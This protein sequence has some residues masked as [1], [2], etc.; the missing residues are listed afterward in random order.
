[1]K[2]KL[3]DASAA[4]EAE[5]AP[6]SRRRRKRG[7]RPFWALGTCRRATLIP[8]A[9]VASSTPGSATS[10]ATHGETIPPRVRG[11]A[12]SLRAT[13]GHPAK[14]EAVRGPDCGLVRPRG[15][16][17]SCSFFVAS[18]LSVFLVFSRRASRSEALSLRA[19]TGA[20]GT[21][22]WLSP[23]SLPS[24]FLSAFSWAPSALPALPLSANA[25][26]GGGTS[27]RVVASIPPSQRLRDG[28][29]R[30]ESREPCPAFSRACGGLS[31]AGVSSLPQGSSAS[32]RGAHHQSA[33]FTP[34][35]PLRLL[36]RPS[37]SASSGGARRRCEAQHPRFDLRCSQTGCRGCGGPHWAFLASQA[38]TSASGSRFTC[39]S[40][41]QSASSPSSP[42]FRTLSAWLRAPCGAARPAS[43]FAVS[44]VS[45][46]AAEPI[47]RP[48]RPSS[49][50]A[51]LRPV[52]PG[53]VS[54]PLPVPA[55][56]PKPFYAE[57]DLERAN[58]KREAAQ[59]EETRVRRREEDL[60]RA[61]LARFGPVAERELEWV[62][63]PAEIEGV[64]RA[65]E[66]AAEVLQVAVDFVK[67]FG[68]GTPEAPLT[69]DA[70]DRVVHEATIAR[71]AYPSPLRYSD[72]PKSVCTSTNE[73][74]C[75]GIPDDRPLQ[76]G[77]IC[78]IDVSCFVD[79]FH[80]DCARTVAIGG[81]GALSQALRRLLVTAREAT[82]EGIRACAPGRKL[83]VIGE[84]IDAFLTRRGCRTIPVFCGHGIGRN[85]HEEPFVLHAANE[86]PGR[87]LP[88]MCFTIEPVVCVGGT[89][90]TT[91]PDKWTIATTDGQ[92]TAQFEHTVLITDTGV[93]IL[94]GCP[95]GDKDME[96]LAK[97]VH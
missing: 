10:P 68:A 11:A 64:R 4:E 28:F 6:G 21:R 30:T 78:S 87:M 36:Q 90:F 31:R 5:E 37:P 47:G 73:I 3:D 91:W 58:A 39:S 57:T 2:H 54:G 55:G 45:S 9:C 46:A 19:G 88:G 82:L 77:S 20:G 97:D 74:V 62:K 44:S 53:T 56:V 26:G 38:V 1:M 42:T 76:R 29:G 86:M 61:R 7:G 96:E 69:T 12:F 72:F 50:E 67:D 51:P 93:E 70:I 25:L 83:S 24:P 16:R 15:G 63:P 34:P 40:R 79:G 81:A 27:A 60:M 35:R 32:S 94:T 17:L 43:A 92:P 23:H 59:S 84:A 18:L 52:G 22:R 66:V 80:G 95:D 8:P 49:P 48:A 71:G 75:H 41:W 13:R 65:C 89:D 33:D 14:K 85:F